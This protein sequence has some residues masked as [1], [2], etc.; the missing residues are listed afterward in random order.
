MPK[1]KKKKKNVFTVIHV[2]ALL[3]NS[4]H[5]KVLFKA[6]STIIKK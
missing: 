4:N 3:A 1:E 5:F 2:C 6:D